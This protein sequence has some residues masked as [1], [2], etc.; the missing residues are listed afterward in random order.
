LGIN[1][2]C[3]IIFICGIE[4][5]SSQTQFIDVHFSEMD[6]IECQFFTVDKLGIRAPLLFER[7]SEKT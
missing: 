5:I 3:R 4:I 2:N 6:S 7:A 1:V